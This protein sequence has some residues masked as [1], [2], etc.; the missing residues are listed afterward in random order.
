MDHFYGSGDYNC[1]DYDEDGI[2]WDKQLEEDLARHERNI[3]MKEIQEYEKQLMSWEDNDAKFQQWVLNI[4]NKN[5]N[6]N[7]AAKKIQSIMKDWYCY[8]ENLKLEAAEYEEERW[9]GYP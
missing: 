9:Y 2:D 5:P 8:I 7:K 4:D 1:D 3:A 6:I